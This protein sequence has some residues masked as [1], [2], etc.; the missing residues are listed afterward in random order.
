MKLK[1]RERIVP[2][3]E[4]MARGKEQWFVSHDMAEAARQRLAEIRDNKE[5]YSH[6]RARAA[7][8][9]DALWGVRAHHTTEKPHQVILNAT[10]ARFLRSVLRGDELPTI[11][12]GEGQPARLPS[13]AKP[14]YKES[15]TKK[16][17]ERARRATAK[18]E[19]P[20][21]AAFPE[22]ALAVLIPAGLAAVVAHYLLRR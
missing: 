16:Q 10:E 7:D 14:Q 21:K 3:W 13:G 20:V 12:S 2:K 11:I 22:H 15:E 1:R 8:V 9:S 4:K 17:H 19:D 18:G 5:Y 6:I